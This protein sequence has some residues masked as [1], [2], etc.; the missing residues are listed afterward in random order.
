MKFLKQFLFTAA[1]FVVIDVA[2]IGGLMIN[3]YTKAYGDLGRI[4]DGKLQAALVPSIL[5]YFVIPLGIVLTAFRGAQHR[6]QAVLQAALYGF[7]AYATYD[8]TNLAVLRDWSVVGTIV[9]MAWGT[10]LCAIVAAITWRKQFAS[11]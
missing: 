10:V 5:V 8:L 1:V 2:W 7:F 9:D 11:A 4:V 6:R 3:F